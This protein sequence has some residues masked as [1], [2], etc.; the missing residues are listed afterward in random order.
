MK[1]LFGV[2]IAMVTPLDCNEKPDLEA[3]KDL[4]EKLIARGVDCLYPCGT[5]GEMLKLTLEERMA[6]AE[7]VIKTAA[8]RVCVFIHVGADNAAN[9]LALAKHAHQAG[10][11]G[12]GIVT[13]Q[14]FGCTPREMTNYYDEIASNLP[15]D[16][17]IYMYGIPQ[18][19]ANDILPEVAKDLYHRHPNIVG[20]KYSFLDMDRTNAYLD[21][22]PDFSVLHG[23]D[24]LFTSML[25][26]GCDGTVSGVGGVMPEPFV[27]IYKAYQAGDLAAAQKW[28]KAGRQICTILKN[29][30]NMAIFKAALEHRGVKAGQMRKPQMALPAEE[31]AA[32][33]AQLDEYFASWGLDRIL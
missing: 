22:A 10:A 25:I 11:D 28:Q 16:F 6:V 12:V 24:R 4:T 29:G 21:I 19:A 17:P 2:T 18:C 1:K 8:G 30:S 3:V 7:T 31:V 26:L 27:N 15:D 9:T 5:T 32:L 23:C 14:F 20:M 13:P 33:T